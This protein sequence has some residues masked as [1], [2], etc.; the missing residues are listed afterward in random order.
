MSVAVSDP[1]ASIWRSIV[2]IQSTF[3]S[4]ASFGASGVMVGPNDV[5]TASHAL[6]MANQGGA[7]TSVT[8]TPAVWGSDPY[9]Q[10]T[11]NSFHYFA[12]YD[13]TNSGMLMPGDGNPSTL[14][15]SELDVGIIDLSTPLGNQ[16]GW[17]QLDPN[18]TSGN[19]NITGFPAADGWQ[20]TNDYTGAYK[21]PTDSIVS[22]GGVTLN[23]GTS[24][25]PV[26]YQG[27]DGGHVVGVVSTTSWG[28]S[29]QGTYNDLEN[30]IHGNDY[31]IGGTQAT[32][33]TGYTAPTTDTSTSTGTSTSTDTSGSTTTVDTSSSDSKSTDTGGSTSTTTA[34][35][36]TSTSTS[37]TSDAHSVAHTLFD[38]NHDGTGDL[39]LR[40]TS[41]GALA[42]HDLSGTAVTGTA[43]TNLAAGTDWHIAGTGDFNGDG[44][45]DVLW[46]QDGGQVALW[47]M[48]GA[49]VQSSGAVGNADTSQHIVGVGDFD[50]DHKSDILWRGDDGTVST[51]QMNDHSIVGGGT[52]GQMSGDWHVAGTGDFSGDGKCDILWRNDNGSVAMWLM[53]GTTHSAVG[54][55]AS[56]PSDWHVA[57][58]GDFNGD[59]HSDIVWQQDSGAVSIWLMDGQNVVGGWGTVTGTQPG[60]KLA[61]IGDVNN[62]HHADLVW[63]DASGAMKVELMDSLHVVG[64][65]SLA[66]IGTDWVVS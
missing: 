58:I 26:W 4:G 29:V 22:Y 38:F 41:G 51:W 15:G 2:F 45:G 64:S 56:A 27:S 37:T 34:T 18:F 43:T 33:D 47:S 24:G 48:N 57:G 30:W 54:V 40:N 28:A 59:Q 31:L 60:W 19:V 25:G 16:T 55:I 1:T 52:V 10:A 23:P 35:T 50:G 20:M 44:S 17:M 46:R 6:Y 9:G 66:S 8:V 36:T 49:S 63:Q 21:S 39:V 3:P 32:T 12:N 5:L 65:G 62:D 7:A 53:N 13:P 42:I 14:S 61:G 11:S